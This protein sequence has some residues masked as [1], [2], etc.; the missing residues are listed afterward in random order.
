MPPASEAVAVDGAAAGIVPTASDVVAPAPPASTSTKPRK[1]QRADADVTRAVFVASL[2]LSVFWW[3]YGSVS[4]V[5]FAVT[6]CV[7]AA[8]DRFAMKTYKA[9]MA[10]PD[11]WLLDFKYPPEF[12]I[13]NMTYPFRFVNP[14]KLNPVIVRGT[15]HIPKG[16][17]RI[18]FVGNHQNLAVDVPLM[19]PE[20]YR[21]TGF[22]ARAV[23]DR[24]HDMIPF[25]KHLIMYL[26]GFPGTREATQAVMQRGDPCIVYPGGAAEVFKGKEDPPYGLHWKERLGFVRMAAENGYRIV[27]FA[28]VGAADSI[29]I[30]FTIPTKFLWSLIGD[31][32][33]KKSKRRATFSQRTAPAAPP[34][35]GGTDERTPPPKHAPGSSREMGDSLPVVM[36][37]WLHP[38]TNYVWFGEPIDASA[39]LARFEAEELQYLQQ[40][41]APFAGAGGLN[42]SSSSSSEDDERAPA[43]D[44]RD[45]WAAEQARLAAAAREAGLRKVRDVV[46]E[47][48]EAGIRECLEWREADPERF[49]DVP[50]KVGEAVKEVGVKAL[51][52]VVGKEVAATVVGALGGAGK[53][54]AKK[55]N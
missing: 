42:S 4:Q 21:A 32:R 13:Y 54:E 26:G 11:R 55:S 28:S 31:P 44:E 34:P 50:A 20:L 51:E 53:K 17:S 41:A 29:K 47:Q 7:L 35:A 48:V 3:R 38:Q 10:Y 43:G 45:E 23:T 24:S 25:Y 2:L 19:F 12:V 8:P 49:N 40:G 39:L 33:A 15:E 52:R 30:W 27:P 37:F 16:G 5:L 46:K 1:P 18:L 6:V 36:P 22:Y 9:F 14:V